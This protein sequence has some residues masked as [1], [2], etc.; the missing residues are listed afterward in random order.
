MDNYILAIE[1]ATKL[2]SVGIAKNGVLVALIELN[3]D[4]YTHA[5]NIHPFIVKALEEVGIQASSLS[6]ISV[7]KGPGSYTGLRIGVSA[8]KG[9]SYA[10]KIPLIGIE[11]L[12][13]LALAIQAEC[14]NLT[15]ESVICPVI[16]ARR[17]EVFTRW[18]DQKLN[19]INEVHAA[20]IEGETILNWNNQN[21][22]L[23]GD[24][25]MKL[26]ETLPNAIIIEDVMPSAKY[27]LALA[28]KAFQNSN[29][30]SIAYFEPYYLKDFVA[31]KP[32]KM[33]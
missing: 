30:E 25:A 23:G 32:K 28:Y 29:F 33:L 14:K 17:M 15:S 10:L 3:N 21:M 26:A 5:E 6:A 31:G 19:P 20:I 11:T 27:Q 13:V 8:A 1:T 2:C 22:V 24:G 18:Y 9:L 12:D 4:N 16:D 7:S